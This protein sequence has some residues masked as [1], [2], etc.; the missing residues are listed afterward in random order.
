VLFHLIYGLHKFA[1]AEII[2]STASIEHDFSV[3]RNAINDLQSASADL[4]DEKKE[5]EMCFRNLLRKLHRRRSCRRRKFRRIVDWIKWLFSACRHHRHQHYHFGP[6]CW[7]DVAFGMAKIVVPDVHERHHGSPEFP[8]HDLIKAAKR[9]R[10][11]N[12]KLA[13]FERGFISKEGIRN[14]EWY[15]HLGVAPGLWL[16]ESSL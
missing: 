3:V 10:R 8:A 12:Q 4:D 13:A 1:S 16:G 5:A 7:T 14:R 9:V 11:V 2:A 15:K 6:D